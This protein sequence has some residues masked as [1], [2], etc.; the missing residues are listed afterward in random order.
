MHYSSLKFLDDFPVGVC[1]FGKDYRIR[2]WNRRM[3]VWTGY[4][5]QEVI[6]KDARTLFPKLMEPKYQ[7]RLDMLFSG[8]A[9]AIFSALL[10]TAIFT[11]RTKNHL[12]SVFNTTAMAQETGIAGE[13]D[14]LFVVED[15]TAFHKRT[16]QLETI[17]TQLESF[18]HAASHDLRAPLRRMSYFSHLIKDELAEQASEDM[19]Q[20]LDFLVSQ[21]R[22]LDSLLIALLD[23][24]RAASGEMKMAS[25]SLA[26]AVDRAVSALQ[27]TLEEA[28]AHVFYDA[29]PELQCDVSLLSLVFQ[30]LI[31]NAVKYNNAPTP[32]VDIRATAQEG[33]WL[34]AVRD[35][36]IGVDPDYLEKIFLP[37]K[38]LHGEQE[39]AG[40]GI[41]LSTCQHIIRRHQGQIWAENNAD[42]AGATFYFTVGA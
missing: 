23:Y 42:G 12:H 9:P 28:N 21:S 5:A 41:G 35:N 13:S 6:W 4:E 16:E 3:E 2:M 29:L 33:E 32:T 27:Q 15:V 19:Q 10:H 40:S 25:V 24:S 14:I 17:N 20:Y 34:I 37:F 30:N 31:G 8:G 1:L 18:V 36:G 38:R 39:Y 7:H 11:P 26:E 22:Q